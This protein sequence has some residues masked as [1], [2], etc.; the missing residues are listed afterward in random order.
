MAND[1]I[2]P[3]LSPV[4]AKK[5]INRFCYFCTIAETILQLRAETSIVLKRKRLRSQVFISFKTM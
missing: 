1:A 2:S 5:G 4:Y 3:Y